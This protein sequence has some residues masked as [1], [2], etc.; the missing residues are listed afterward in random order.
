MQDFPHHYVVKASALPGE[1]VAIEAE[2]LPEIISA[3]PTQFSGPG[4]KWSPE[5]LMMGAV[6]DC[7]IL[8]FQ[9]IANASRFEWETLSCNVEGTL[10]RI[11][12]VTRFTAVTVTATLTLDASADQGKADRLLHKAEES[13]LVTN[14]MSAET[15]LVTNIVAS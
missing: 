6:A 1:P 7:F 12:R 11:D 14:S 13:C 2:N 3:P 15:Q 8:T 4:D 9:A 5:D 10:D